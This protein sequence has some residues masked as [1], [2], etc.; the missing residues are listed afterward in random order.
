MYKKHVH[1]VNLL[2]LFLLWNKQLII[3]FLWSKDGGILFMSVNPLL[4]LL[5]PTSNSLE[6]SQI[7]QGEIVNS[8]QPVA[9]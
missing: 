8:E 5:E 2:K 4:V 3:A 9:N 1:S 6:V 7:R